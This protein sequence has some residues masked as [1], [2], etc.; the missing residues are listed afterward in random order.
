[1][2][3]SDCTSGERSIKHPSGSS[4]TIS[5]K[6]ATLLSFKPALTNNISD[7]NNNNNETLWL[8]PLSNPKTELNDDMGI[9][10]GIPI[11]FPN[12]GKGTGKYET[13]PQ[14]GFAR[15][16]IWCFEEVFES[17][18]IDDDSPSIMSLSISFP[19][20]QTAKSAGST[21]WQTSASSTGYKAKLTI[22]FYLSAL[23]FRQT[24]TIENLGSSEFPFQTLLHSYFKVDDYEKCRVTGLEG[25]TCV[26]TQ[27]GPQFSE[28]EFNRFIQLDGSQGLEDKEFDR[29]YYPPPSASKR[30]EEE[31]KGELELTL[32]VSSTKTSSIRAGCTFNDKPF[33]VSVVIWNPHAKKSKLMADFPFCFK[34]MVC[35]E[36]GVIEGMSI[37][38]VDSKAILW[39][40]I[41]IIL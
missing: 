23:S 29:I 16:A 30:L 27:P 34:E 35:V 15:Q 28:G 20:E 8:S 2:Q 32:K 36:P 14:H 6:G 41:S 24:L 17:N 22:T 13:L 38:E 9:Q 21:N 40:E 11:V 7:N 26:D 5:N 1:M 19:L 31:K 25:Y 3:L 37:L 39:Q 4:L 33:P 18:I 10:G 12:F